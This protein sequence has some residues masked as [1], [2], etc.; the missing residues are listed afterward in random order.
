METGR[1][2][3]T[4]FRVAMRRAI[5]Q[6]LDQ[7]CVL[8]DPIAVPLLGPHFTFDREREMSPLARAF[9]AFM[10]ARSRFAED[11]LADAVASGGTQYAVLAR[12]STRLPI[13]IR[14]QTCASS[15]WISPRRRSGNARF[16]SKLQSLCRQSHVCS[17]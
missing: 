14:F 12:D 15:K 6:I 2:S 5:H 17:A 8:V 9:R 13:G 16:W 1:A 4:A 10:A 3:K 7:S 11:R